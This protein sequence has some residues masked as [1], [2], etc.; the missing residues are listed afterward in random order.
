MIDLELAKQEFKNYLQNFDIENEKIKGKIIHTYKVV[1][2]AQYIAEDLKLIKEDLELARLIALL[3]D[4]G[5]FEQAVKYNDFRDSYTEDHAKLG[6]KILF[7]QKL[8]RNF[9]PDTQYDSI[10]YK[11]IANHN[12]LEIEAGLA[13]KELLHSKIIRDADKTDGFRV[14]DELAIET[15]LYLWEK[16]EIENS[17][18]T[19]KI[20][21][22][23]KK[24]R[25]VENKEKITPAD[26]WLGYLAWIYDFN[27]PSG[28]KYIKE[29]GYIQSNLARIHYKN[30]DTE[31]KMK[32]AKEHALAYIENKLAK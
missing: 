6:L 8:I 16:E 4:I 25:M 11:A 26:Y 23:F 30:K 5:R 13:E 3:H 27:F 32:L 7:D 24:D 18:I 28:L 1:E 14:R 17:S 20:W 9:I 21:E 15:I 10:I 31:E 12:R 2:F 19:P 22:I 29:K